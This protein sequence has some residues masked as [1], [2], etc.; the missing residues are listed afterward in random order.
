MIAGLI[1]RGGPE[2]N[3]RARPRIAIK[4]DRRTIGKFRVRTCFFIFL[5]FFAGRDARGEKLAD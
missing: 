4:E 2:M 3:K 1:R 5:F